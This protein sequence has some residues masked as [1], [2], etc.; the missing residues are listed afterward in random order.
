MISIH[1]IH[2]V[3]IYNNYMKEFSIDIIT[4]VHYS[5]QVFQLLCGE[6]FHLVTCDYATRV[7]PTSASNHINSCDDVA[8]EALT[9]C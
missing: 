4:Q 6:T 3:D 8:T 9:S 1:I 7:C 5:I 2:H